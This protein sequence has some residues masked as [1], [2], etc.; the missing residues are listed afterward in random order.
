MLFGNILVALF[1]LVIILTIISLIPTQSST[2]EFIGSSDGS[3]AT[4]LIIFSISVIVL[5]KLR[6][7]H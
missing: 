5:I 7:R 6:N 2:G 4:F 1:V 3:L